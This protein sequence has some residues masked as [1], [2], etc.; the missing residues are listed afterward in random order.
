[1]TNQ[2]V[3]IKWKEVVVIIVNNQ[4]HKCAKMFEYIPVEEALFSN[5]LGEFTS[6]GIKVFLVVDK[7]YEIGV[8]SDVSDD[9]FTVDRI[10][11]Y[12]NNK[13]INPLELHQM[14]SLFIWSDHNMSFGK[15]GEYPRL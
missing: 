6:F 7:K 3:I 11:N 4:W 1:M 14:V 10:V 15:R 2:A 9:Q 8:A 5:D 13:Q 12:C